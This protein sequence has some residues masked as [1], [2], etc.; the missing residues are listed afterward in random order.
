MTHLDDREALENKINEALA[1]KDYGEFDVEFRTIP[2]DGKFKWL[3]AK[4][5]AYFNEQGLATR[6]I[7]TLLDITIQKLIDVATME[8]LRKKDEFVSIAS[9]E[10]KTPITSLKLLLQM[11]ERTTSKSDEMKAFSVTV[12]KSIK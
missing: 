6:F 3:K 12:T 10:L 5:R 2:F 9:H 11:M 7:G 8:L 4:G 1:N